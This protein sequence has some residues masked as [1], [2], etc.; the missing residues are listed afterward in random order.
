ML[1]GQQYQSQGVLT[2]SRG[3]AAYEAGIDFIRVISVRNKCIDGSD[4]VYSDANINQSVWSEFV[5]GC[6]DRLQQMVSHGTAQV[7][8]ALETG[9]G[10]GARERLANKNITSVDYD[11]VY[12]YGHRSKQVNSQ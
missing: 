1:D 6:S 10:G 12:N 11:K 5:S 2:A 9:G 7:R 4:G 8:G 3:T